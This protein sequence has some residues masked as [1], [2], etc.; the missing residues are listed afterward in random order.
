MKRARQQQ[1]GYIFLRCGFWYVR[2][3]EDVVLENGVVKRLQQ[4]CRLTRATG[5]YRTKRAVEQLAERALRP[6]NDGVV[7]AEST[8]SLNRFIESAYF[9]YAAQQKRRSTYRG[10]RNIWKRYIKPNG[11]RALREYRTFECEQMLLSI[12][13]REDLCRTTLGHIKHFLSGVFR[14]AR[15]QGVLDTAN[16]I[17]DVEIPKARPAGE[18]Q[19]Y[20]LEEEVRMLGILPEPAATAVAVAA[21]TG[22]RKGEIR[23]LLWEDYYDCAI[24]V[25]QAVWRS[26]VDEP[27]RERSKGSIPVI[28]QLKFFLDR[29]RARSG[30]PHQ[31]YIFRSPQ[32]KP[33]NLD[34]LARDVIRPALEAAKLPWHGWHAFRRGLATNLNRLGVSDKVIQQILRHANVT[35]T[36]N[37]YVKMVSQDATAAMKTLEANCATT[38]QQ[39]RLIGIPQEGETMMEHEQQASLSERHTGVLAERE[40]SSNPRYRC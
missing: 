40:G 25:K 34:A 38:V 35:T 9:P 12:A 8:M 20:S 11:D 13:R 16:P 5:A 6:L 29:H 15:R 32:G 19:A 17:H 39:E 4:C 33:L 27:K 24:K 21:F 14:Y 7:A 37:I 31:G 18:T 23:G 30:Y 22:A 28:A 10:Y 26:H 2:Y 3:R 36:M 1:A